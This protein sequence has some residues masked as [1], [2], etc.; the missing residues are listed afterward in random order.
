MAQV[1]ECPGRLEELESPL[2]RQG[3]MAWQVAEEEIRVEGVIL[4]EDMHVEGA[5]DKA[6]DLRK[7][8]VGDVQTVREVD[9]MLEDSA[10]V[11]GRVG[12][13][14]EGFS[15]GHMDRCREQDVQDVPN[16]S[17]MG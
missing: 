4:R 3:E 7:E 12:I 15:V 14:A 16:S 8:K 9:G 1:E 17:R 10:A 13:V 6:V 5:A 11:E 2:V